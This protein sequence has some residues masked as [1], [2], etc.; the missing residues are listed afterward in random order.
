MQ[1]WAFL[2]ELFSDRSF[3]VQAGQS[4]VHQYC[5]CLWIANKNTI[6]QSR[7]SFQKVCFW[8]YFNKSNWLKRYET[9][10][11]ISNNIKSASRFLN[12]GTLIAILH[13]QTPRLVNNK[14]IIH[15]NILLIHDGVL[16]V[17][18]AVH[19][20]TGIIHIINKKIHGN[21]LHRY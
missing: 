5:L 15:Q 1:L 21:F 3:S 12:W 4:T 14:K 16:Q 19:H 11:K 20:T 18:V 6:L 13:F 17:L 10:I 8:L 2:Q 9:G 7:W